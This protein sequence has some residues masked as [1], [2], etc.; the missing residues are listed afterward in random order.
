MQKGKQVE[1]Y[2]YP[3]MHNKKQHEYLR[4]SLQEDCH[5]YGN[6]K[7]KEGFQKQTFKARREQEQEDIEI[8]PQ[9]SIRPMTALISPSHSY[10]SRQ[11]P[12]TAPGLNVQVK[13]MMKIDEND[14]MISVPYHSEAKHFRNTKTGDKTNQNVIRN[15]STLK[16]VSLEGES[17]I[18]VIEDDEAKNYNIIEKQTVKSSL[19]SPKQSEQQL[20]GGGFHQN[21]TILKGGQHQQRLFKHSSLQIYDNLVEIM[22]LINGQTYTK[23]PVIVKTKPQG[24][25]PQSAVNKQIKVSQRYRPVSGKV[26]S[27]T[28]RGIQL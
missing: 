10:S 3:V 2:F 8:G 21:T 18:Y 15:H 11:R 25:R 12:I 27:I 24:L 19:F 6:Q 26:Q 28:V 23:S 7:T 9:K 14:A 17:E 16:K 4:Q 1:E 13:H 22:K 20:T 5:N